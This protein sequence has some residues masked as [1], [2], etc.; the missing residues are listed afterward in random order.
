MNPPP[1]VISMLSGDGLKSLAVVVDSISCTVVTPRNP[2]HQTGEKRQISWHRRS[3]QL[4][5]TNQPKNPAP[6][7]TAIF[8]PSTFVISIARAAICELLYWSAS[9]VSFTGS[10]NWDFKHRR[11]ADNSMHFVTFEAVISPDRCHLVQ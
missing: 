11:A 6:F 8:K 2:Q 9:T 10:S 5:V 7:V 1:P 4:P 3:G